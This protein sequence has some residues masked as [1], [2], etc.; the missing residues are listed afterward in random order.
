MCQKGFFSALF[1][2][3]Q[4]FVFSEFGGPVLLS[5]LISLNWASK[6][7]HRSWRWYI[8]M[9][10]RNDNDNDC[11]NDDDDGDVL[12]ECGLGRHSNHS[13]WGRR[14]ELHLRAFKEHQSNCFGDVFIGWQIVELG[15]R[16][17][18]IGGKIS[19]SSKIVLWYMSTNDFFS[20]M[21]KQWFHDWQC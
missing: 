10:Y 15:Y 2:F 11:N 9:K 16:H 14:R 19:F 8:H 20:K 7:F 21:S 4:Y 3:H 6:F 18:F 13:S 12:V 1:Y 5:A 17:V